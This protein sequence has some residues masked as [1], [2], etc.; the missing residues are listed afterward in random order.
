MKKVLVTGAAGFIG[1]N[2]CR[3]LLEAG[4]DVVG[5]DDLSAGTLDNVPVQL[6][7]RKVDICE[8]EFTAQV[9]G[10][11]TVFHLAAKNC[12]ADCA[13]NPAETSRINVLGT[14]KVVEACLQNGV[15]H[16]VYSDTSAEY[17]G[18]LD[19]PSKTDRVRPLSIYACSKRGG[20]LA[21]DALCRLHKLA[22]STVRYFNVYGPAQDWRRVIPPV[23]SAF[24]IKL[25]S[26]EAPT[27][28]GTGE[29]SR[30]FIHVD[31]V[32]RFHIQLIEDEAIRGG[33]FN[34]GS[35]EA[36]SILDI[37][38]KTEAILRTGLSPV[39]K[40]EL[41]GE[42]ERTLADIS[43]TLA[44]GWKPEVS[45][46]QGLQDFVEYIRP[47]LG[48]SIVVEQQSTLDPHKEIQL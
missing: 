27:I 2:L 30:D 45:I 36:Y 34:L 17:E 11:D 40:P 43:D 21:A 6:D 19:F 48:K 22:L 3:G 7:F 18:I 46:E 10:I 38:K 13:A 26:N 15:K 23:M 14:T 32:N 16:L 41:P 33:T 37:F 28:Y 12:L 1:S 44:T 5:V 9:K 4:Y 8:P 42:A 47:R 29:K 31:D 39:F 35:G 25:L 24:T 20:W